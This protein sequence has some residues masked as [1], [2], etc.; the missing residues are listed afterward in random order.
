MNEIASVL[1]ASSAS[2]SDASGSALFVVLLVLVFGLVIG[3]NG[4]VIF[5]RTKK[6][7]HLFDSITADPTNWVAIL[8]GQPVPRRAT[9][10]LLFEIGSAWSNRGH[11]ALALDDATAV[12]RSLRSNVAP[13]VDRNGGALRF[14]NGIFV[15]S[16]RIGGEELQ[17]GPVA[18]IATEMARLGWTVLDLP[19]YH[20]PRPA[21]LGTWVGPRPAPPGS[22]AA[23][24]RTI[25]REVPSV[26]TSLVPT[27]RGIPAGAPRWSPASAR[28]AAPPDRT[29]PP[30]AAM[31]ADIE[32]P[33]SDAAGDIELGTDDLGM[34]IEDW[35]RAGDLDE[36]E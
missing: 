1:A 14:H 4:V 24:V 20:G 35:M 25:P 26:P 32:M 19:A 2:S 17:E 28:L 9:G 3:L 36:I 23:P 15:K 11:Y 31:H 10:P 13:I 5:F 12:V 21:H 18:A 27:P 33:R 30:A 22:G 6:R 16:L 8:S 7:R 34:A 29:S